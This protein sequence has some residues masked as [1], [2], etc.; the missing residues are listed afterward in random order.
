[1]P[2]LQQYQWEI[3]LI[4]CE[5]V[6]QSNSP[7]DS[8]AR[9]VLEIEKMPQ[10]Y[11]SNLLQIIRLYRESVT[12]KTTTVDAWSKAI[13]DLKNPDP[14]V[15]AA[16]QKALSELLRSWREEGD[17]QEQKETWEILSKAF[18]EGGVSI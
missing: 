15:K 9:I 12:M 1:M 6:K 5:P 2:Y 8:L 17:E 18:N 16:R 7:Q 3:E 11:W 14:V 13:D 10:E 4:M